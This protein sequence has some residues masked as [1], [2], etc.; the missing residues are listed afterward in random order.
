MDD[1]LAAFA[2]AVQAD[3]AVGIAG[4]EKLAKLYDDDT[5]IGPA[6][7]SPISES[8]SSD[9]TQVAQLA[10][11]DSAE[12]TESRIPKGVPKTRRA[13]IDTEHQLWGPVWGRAAVLLG[14]GVSLATVIGV[15]GWLVVDTVDGGQRGN[16]VL[17]RG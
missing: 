14:L 13:G 8:A 11:S 12:N 3:T 15:G 9:E 7:V 2:D 17:P 10:W 5:A 6:I 4:A 1:D 16:T